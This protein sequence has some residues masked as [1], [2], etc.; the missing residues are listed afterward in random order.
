MQP[1]NDYNLSQIVLDYEA[2]RH[3]VE[4]IKQQEPATSLIAVVKANAYGHGAVDIAKAIESDVTMF[5]VAQPIEAI[6][7]RK[8]GINKP[9]LVLCAPDKRWSDVYLTWNITAVASSIDHLIDLPTGTQVHIKFDTGMNRLG[10]RPS[11]VPEILHT[12]ERR[13]DLIVGG[14]MTHFANADLPSH[15][16]IEQQLTLF[17]QISE[18]FPKEWMRH[19]SNS[20]AVISGIGITFDAVR[21]GLML[22]GYV[23][24]G[25]ENP[26][27]LPVKQWVSAISQVRPVKKD[28]AVSYGWTWKA[29]SD[30]W[31][32]VVPI[33]YADGYPRS[34]SSKSVVALIDGQAQL[35]G[36]VTMDYIMIWTDRRPLIV[37][38]KVIL[39]GKNGCDAND[40][41][42][43]SGTIAYE[44][45]CQTGRKRGG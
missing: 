8:S 18:V 44:I 6:E 34:L 40:L 19:I 14:L 3:N 11:Q 12:L 15:P 16:S 7:L 4:L 30:G 23:P 41:A 37:G 24:G 27:L 20:A 43:A 5:A 2:L 28:E 22:Y 42:A 29:P 21:V 31:I 35:A 13:E 45:L 10:F 9:I 39:L 36:R 32:G 33:G 26:G 1:S 25:M 38:E 17:N